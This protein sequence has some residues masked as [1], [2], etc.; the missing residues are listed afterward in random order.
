MP[1]LN[2]SYAEIKDEGKFKEYIQA[3]GVLM[4][5]AGIDVE[6]VI[7][8]TYSTTIR[9][10]KCTPHIAAVFRYPDK[11]AFEK[12]YSSKQYKALLPLRDEAC[13]MTINLYEE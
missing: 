9:G 6:V 7:R 13:N 4:D 12:F 8:G 10:D 1:I 2:F 3:A 5:E 11:V